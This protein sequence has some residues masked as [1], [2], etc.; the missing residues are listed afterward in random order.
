MKQD[1]TERQREVYDFLLAFWRSNGYPPA[2]REVAAH[3]GFRST[4]A[5]VDHLNALERKGWIVR[6][7]ERS[8][9]IEFPRETM[10]PTADVVELPVVGRI[11]AGE[12]ILAVE[13]VV[14]QVAMDRS[15][16]R[17]KTPF[18]LRVVGDSM[19]DAGIYED[20]YVLVSRQDVA[21]DGEIVVALLE[22]DATVKRL[23]KRGGEVSL[24]PANDAYEPIQVTP[25]QRFSLVGRV[26]G[27][28]RKM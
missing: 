3:F 15:W 28:F 11:A 10:A 20:D 18:L 5:V 14:D 6:G 26:V 1:L 21:E 12:P 2:I 4:R 7:R 16:V 19:K 17:G 22:D 13:N 23:R 27:L 9:A 24:E 25:D 8:R